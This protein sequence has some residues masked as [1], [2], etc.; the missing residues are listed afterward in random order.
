MQAW[1]WLHLWA[2]RRALRTWADFCS[3][4]VLFSSTVMARASKF[5]F[6]EEEKREML[7]E[8]WGRQGTLL[9]QKPHDSWSE[10]IIRVGIGLGQR[11]RTTQKEKFEKEG[12]GL[13][14]TV[15]GESTGSI[16]KDWERSTATPLLSQQVSRYHLT[17][18]ISFIVRMILWNRT[19]RQL[20]PA[21][22]AHQTTLKLL[23]CSPGSQL[24]LVKTRQ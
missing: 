18:A 21:C 15:Y 17:L 2:Q 8:D 14:G 9:L 16:S 5:T 22:K 10:V 20:V 1:A 4:A 3:L 7:L 12:E 24:T 11:K 23:S 19:R 6:E 13:Q